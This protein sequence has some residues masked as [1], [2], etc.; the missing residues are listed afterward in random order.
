MPVV[1]CSGIRHRICV[2][3]QYTYLVEKS[4]TEVNG[5]M[6]IALVMVASLAVIAMVVGIIAISYKKV[7]QGQ[8]LVIS[9]WNKDPKVS[10]TNVMAFPFIH[11]VEVMDITLKTMV[12]SFAGREKLMC[13][14]SVGVHIEVAFQIRVNPT[15][16]DVLKVARAMGCSQAGTLNKLREV[17]LPLF[18][19]V[20]HDVA[21]NIDS[22]EIDSSRL[23][24]CEK[25]IMEAGM[26]M[27]GFLL[28]TV[29]VQSF[30]K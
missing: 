21:R 20:V 17:F 23:L 5:V 13:K 28:E 3:V 8:A 6:G 7:S 2:L 22:D 26:D 16:E 15:T 25:L 1:V 9:T 4:M 18:T 10:F 29:A 19:T 12:V 24:F 27:G 30:S 14:D 11:H